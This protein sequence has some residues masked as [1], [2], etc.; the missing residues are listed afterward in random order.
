MMNYSVR[1]QFLR[2]NFATIVTS[3]ITEVVC[4][5]R[6][7]FVPLFVHLV[8][9]FY[10]LLFALLSSSEV[11]RVKIFLLWRPVVQDLNH[12]TIS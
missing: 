2:M 10:Q 7:V 1:Q 5:L 12:T 11:F 3:S 8:E 6:Q 4:L 9:D